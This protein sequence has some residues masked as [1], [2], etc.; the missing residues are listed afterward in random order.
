MWPYNI[1]KNAVLQSY[2]PSAHPLT[3]NM[4]NFVGVHTEKVYDFLPTE[5]SVSQDTTVVIRDGSNFDLCGDRRY[6]VTTKPGGPVLHTNIDE[7]D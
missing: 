1:C 4:Y 5:D 6:Y 2:V 7:I 3:D